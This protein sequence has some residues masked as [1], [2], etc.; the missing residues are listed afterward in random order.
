MPLPR[1]IAD[2]ALER[3]RQSRR[4]PLLP[5]TRAQGPVQDTYTA[6]DDFGWDQIEEYLRSKWPV[7][8]FKPMK[9]N[10]NWLFEVPERLNECDRRELRRRRD[11]PKRTRRATTSP[12]QEQ[13]PDPE[14]SPVSTP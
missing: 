3:T 10:G 6:Y 2:L 5:S 13:E 1:R 11:A 4:R 8:N 12:E 7:W 14:S 9:Y